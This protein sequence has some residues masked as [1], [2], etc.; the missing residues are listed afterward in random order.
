MATNPRQRSEGARLAASTISDRLREIRER[1]GLAQK[2]MSSHLGLGAN[3]WQNIEMGKNLPSGETLL[4]LASIGYSPTWVLTGE[5]P[6]DLSPGSEN[7][8]IVGHSPSSELT[9]VAFLDGNH[10]I[11]QPAVAPSGVA[12]FVL[13]DDP[14]RVYVRLPLFL[15]RPSAGPGI[16]VRDERLSANLVFSADWLWQTLR[17]PPEVLLC[18]QAHGDSMS[19]R[20]A[21]G[22]VLIVDTSVDRVKDHGIYVFS[23]EGDLMV[24]RLYRDIASRTLRIT[25]E[26]DNYPEQILPSSEANRIN[27]VGMVVWHGG[28]VR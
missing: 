3:T 19:P 16:A 5:G 24:K 25:S 26:N 1:V 23:Y 21:H 12:S 2:K 10:P 18:M 27:V 14:E 11:V 17:R 4:K 6:R 15:P 13:A 22:D 7:R 28:I 9:Q 20:I 8:E